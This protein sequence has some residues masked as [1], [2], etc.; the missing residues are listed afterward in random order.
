MLKR[1]RTA[2]LAVSVAALLVVLGVGAAFAAGPTTPT[3]ATSYHQV[4]VGKVA[5]I[6]GIDQQKVEAALTQAQSEAL[7]QAVQDGRLTQQQADWMKQRMAAGGSGMGFGPGP[8]AGFGNASGYGPGMMA[9]AGSGYGPGFMRGAAAG[10]CPFVG[11]SQ[12][13]PTATPAG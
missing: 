2:L 4:V 6:L 13:A 12:V 11:T 8:G 1:Y 7:D 5:S 10:T 3:A 9:G